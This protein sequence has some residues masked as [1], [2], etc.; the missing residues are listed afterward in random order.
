MSVF[1]GCGAR[2]RPEPMRGAGPSGPDVRHR[3]GRCRR[4]RPWRNRTSRPR[5]RRWWRTRRPWSRPRRAGRWPDVR[6]AGL[7][8][9]L[10]SGR[11]L[12]RDGPCLPGVRHRGLR[13]CGRRNRV[14]PRHG[15]RR[16]ER[17]CGARRRWGGPGPGSCGVRRA[18]HPRGPAAPRSRAL[19]RHGQQR[20]PRRPRHG[21]RRGAGPCA[22]PLLRQLGSKQRGAGP[23]IHLLRDLAHQLSH[24]R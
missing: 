10:R 14:R 18:L 7:R 24:N 21:A 8:W 2:S 4:C 23:G 16:T 5:C 6:C 11:H 12:T 13:R 3:S 17:R 15:R 20:G 1:S 9:L 19:R 22:E